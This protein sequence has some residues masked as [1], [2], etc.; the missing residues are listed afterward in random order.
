[1]FTVEQLNKSPTLQADDVLLLICCQERY[2]DRRIPQKAEESTPKTGL[3][4]A[5]YKE[6]IHPSAMGQITAIR[7]DSAEPSEA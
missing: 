4:N 6:A 7:E 3:R 1:M 2:P 5:R